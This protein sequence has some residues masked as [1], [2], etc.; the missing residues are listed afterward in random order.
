VAT[1]QSSLT[2]LIDDLDLPRA[3]FEP[4]G[5]ARQAAE[6]APSSSIVD[7]ERLGATVNR[8]YLILFVAASASGLLL[9]LLIVA[10]W[11]LPGGTNDL[12]PAQWSPDYQRLVVTQAAD[13]YS[14]TGNAGQA[15][16]AFSD[17]NPADLAQL[18]ASMQQETTDAEARRRLIALTQALRLPIS[19]SS[20][21]SFIG[22]PAIVLG[23][24]LSALPLLVAFA[25][26]SLPRLRKPQQALAGIPLGEQIQSEEPLDDLV[27]LESVDPLETTDQ[28]QNEE[29]EQKKEEEAQEETD[30]QSAGLGDLASLFEE[31]DTSINALEAFCK[32]MPE[33]NVDALLATAKN[34][35]HQL[36]HGSVTSFAKEES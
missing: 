30:D 36:R 14:Q 20:A 17:W 9:G 5:P 13:N 29:E 8:Q 31:E 11:L 23:A 21:T 24:L 32:G 16:A 19:D 10:L 12:N 22:Q 6:L 1:I 7:F 3:R 2:S 15:Q 33:V 34:I 35:V 28:E 25:I 4:K 27:G 26:V 18:L